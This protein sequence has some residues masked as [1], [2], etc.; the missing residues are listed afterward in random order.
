MSRQFGVHETSNERFLQQIQP[1][2]FCS[3]SLLNHRYVLTSAR[4]LCSRNTMDRVLCTD[5]TKT[6]FDIHPASLKQIDVFIGALNDTR[7]R[8]ERKIFAEK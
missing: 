8:Q 7:Y 2:V 1:P 4:C 6:V 5:P 3:G